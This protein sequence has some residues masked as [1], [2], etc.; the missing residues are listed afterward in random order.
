MDGRVTAAGLVRFVV[1]KSHP[2]SHLYL[3]HPQLPA[4]A[5]AV[6]AHFAFTADLI[7]QQRAAV[8]AAIVVSG[9]RKKNRER[10][11]E[12]ETL[13]KGLLLSTHDGDS[14]FSTSVA[15]GLQ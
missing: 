1:I 9:G 10:K 2:F 14:I 8:C 15:L 12:K 5:R 3:T 4:Q 7:K 13:C 6:R 11:G